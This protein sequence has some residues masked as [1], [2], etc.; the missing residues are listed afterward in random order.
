MEPDYTLYEIENLNFGDHLC[1]LYS[2][3]KDHEA[4]LTPFLKQG[5]ENHEKVIYIVDSNTSPVVKNYLKSDNIDVESYLKSRQFVI[6]TVKDTYLK[7]GYFDPDKMIKLLKSETETALKNGYSGLRVTGEMTWVLKELPG[8]ERLIE[9]ESKLNIY[10]PYSRCLAIC[11]YDIR[12]FSPDIILKILE[13]HPIIVIGTEFFQNFYYIPPEP[14]LGKNPKEKILHHWINNIKDRKLAEQALNEQ[15][16]QLRERIKELNCLYGI[17]K[18]LEYPDISIEE[19][20]EGTINLIPPAFQFPEIICSRIL[21]N[22]MEY[23]T[24]SFDNSPYNLSYEVIVNQQIMKIDVFYLRNKPFLK[25][26]KIFLKEIGD[27]LK[28]IIEEKIG[29]IKLKESEKEYR[30]AFNRSEFFKELLS[31]DIKNILQVLFLCTSQGLDNLNNEE[32]LGECFKRIIGQIEKIDKLVEN[33]NKFSKLEEIELK[34][35]P[36]DLYE[37]LKKSVNFVQ[38]SSLDKTIKIQIKSTE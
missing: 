37:V 16:H 32:Y 22:S 3:E 29:E 12:K 36:I 9:Y 17:S 2:T 24:D 21:Y 8:S 30:N 11:Q 23:K 5:L 19:I 25:E 13:T 14:Y 34:L 28:L 35:E 15:E 6:L 7:D 38:R 4:L 20:I 10:F 18:L 31:H 33:V 1:C 27:R 26:E